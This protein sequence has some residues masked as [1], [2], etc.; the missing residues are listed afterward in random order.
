M[1]ADL[2]CDLKP[3]TELKV[4]YVA[5]RDHAKGK[6]RHFA[7]TKEVPYTDVWDFELVLPRPGKHPCEKLVEMMRHIV[8]SSSQ[9][10]DVV[11]DAFVDSGSTAVAAYQLGLRWALLSFSRRLTVWLNVRRKRREC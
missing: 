6:G 8:E 7:V 9:P 11:F 1:L 3:Y 5:I 4:E 2:G 10:G